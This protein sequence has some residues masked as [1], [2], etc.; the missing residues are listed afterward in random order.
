MGGAL[1]RYR[2]NSLD[3]KVLARMV[4]DVKKKLQIE[5]L[6]VEKKFLKDQ[7]SRAQTEEEQEEIL[8]QLLQVDKKLAEVKTAPRN[9]KTTL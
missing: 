5:Q 7:H 8:S 3:E 6:K 2:E 4:E 1:F 9:T